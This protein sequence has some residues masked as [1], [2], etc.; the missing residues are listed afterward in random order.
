M[1]R[2][3][4]NWVQV[5]LRAPTVIRG[6]RIQPVTRHDGSQA[7]PV[8]VR[9]QQTNDLTDIFRDY[10][11]LSGRPVQFRLIPN[12]GSGLS[13][14]NLPIPLE[15]RYVR[16]LIQEFVVSPC[17]R[18]ELMGC[19]RQDCVDKNECLE[20]NGGCDQR[21]VNSA[22]GYT[23]ACNVGYE[24]YAHNGTAGFVIPP[25]ETGLRDG[26]VYRLNKTCVPKQCPL[27]TAPKNGQLLSLKVSG[28][29]LLR[30]A[31]NNS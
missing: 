27:L 1:P 26:D 13:V 17:M 10:S 20:K 22:G 19:Q 5:D 12:G 29:R 28:W 30:T 31:G 4:E 18:F 3:G 2:V 9:L 7:Y 16:L 15:A 11:D 8:T 21:C 23:C 6:F 24:L 25:T 14:V